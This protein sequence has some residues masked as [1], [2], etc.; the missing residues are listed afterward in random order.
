MSSRRP[1]ATDLSDEEWW[2]LEPLIP[3]AKPGGRPR[4]HETREILDAIFYAVRGGCAWCLLPHEFPPWQTIYHY[5]RT[6]RLY[7]TWERI[8]SVLRERLR[9]M[10]GREVRPSAAIMDS[11]SVRTTEKG[12]ARGYD[13]AKKVNGRKRHLLVDT[14]GLVMKAR[15]HPADLAD[16]EGA[17]VLLDRVDE[18]FPSL[19]HLWADA[20]YRGVDLR[21]WITEGLGLS[22]EIVQRRSRW[23]WVRNDVEPDP[24][25]N[26]FEVIRRRWVVERTFAWILRN[27]RMSRDYEFLP[28]TGEALIYVTMIRLMLKRLARGVE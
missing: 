12:G 27:R 11:Q 7:G 25:P 6:W 10:A 23:V 13:G 22:L 15:V 5:C 3:E 17:R 9:A 16:R 4:A 28:E 26:G 21:G 18:S 14:G 20:G 8:N 2:I 19:Q 1:Y 24:I